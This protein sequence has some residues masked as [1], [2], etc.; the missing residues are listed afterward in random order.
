[1]RPL[2]V[3]VVASHTS[4][5][6]LVKGLV[7][8][9]R[10]RPA[11][12]EAAGR[13]HQVDRWQAPPFRPLPMVAFG[14]VSQRRLPSLVP[15]AE[16]RYGIVSLGWREGDSQYGDCSSLPE[17]ETQ[18]P[19][20]ILHTEYLKGLEQHFDPDSAEY[21]GRRPLIRQESGIPRLV[22]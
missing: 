17:G 10:E 5:S 15:L 9:V 22:E 7:L 19:T 12:L 16:L 3:A 6:E 20:E 4:L 13:F 2:G 11:S 8:L 21:R 14:L 18:R 1:M